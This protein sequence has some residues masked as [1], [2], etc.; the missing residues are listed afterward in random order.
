MKTRPMWLMITCSSLLL[1]G[2]VAA[3]ATDSASDQTAKVSTKSRMAADAKLDITA[4]QVDKDGTTEGDA[5]VASRLGAQFGMSA[6][7]ITA[8]KEK[9]NTSWGN[10][11]IAHALAANAKSG[12][13]VDQLVQMHADGKGWGQIAASLGLKLGEVVRE[14]RNEDR[15]ARGLVKPDAKVAVIHADKARVGH[16]DVDVHSSTKIE[17]VKIGH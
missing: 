6:D 13:T 1:A 8:E 12:V 16:T 15:V 2:A 17:H 9:L 4:K 7:A 11:A 14:A 5:K 3:Q 10:L